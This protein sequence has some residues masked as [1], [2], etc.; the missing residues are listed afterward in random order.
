V[1]GDSQVTARAAI[2]SDYALLLVLAAIALSGLSLLA[3]R[4]T[5]LVGVLLVIHLGVVF[6]FFL[7][8]PY[9]KMIHGLYR[10]LA[11][12]LSAAEG[13]GNETMNR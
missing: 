3:L 13:R 9:S 5:V 12:I 10:L 6:V 4:A 11:L 2:G 7:M 8:I 1:M